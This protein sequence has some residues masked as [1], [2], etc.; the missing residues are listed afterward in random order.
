MEESQKIQGLTREEL[1]EKV[2]SLPGSKL[3][4]VLGISDVAIAKHCKKLNVPRPPRGY[5]NKVA[6]GHKPK[7]VPLPP[8]TAAVL[9]KE[10]T[11]PVRRRYELPQSAEALHPLAVKLEEAINSA[12]ADSDKRV[13]LRE[14]ELPLVKVTKALAQRT[15]QAFSVIL[16]ETELDKIPFRKSRASYESGYFEYKNERLHL[17][18][19]EAL[20]DTTRRLTA[21][22]KRNYGFPW[23]EFAKDPSG[24]LTFTL[25]TGNSWYVNKNVMHTW[26][27]DSKNAVEKFLPQIVREICQF[28][29][30]VRKRKAQ[31]AIER[32]KERVE[33]E[34]RRRKY[35]EELAIRQRAEREREH[36][37][38]LDATADARGKDLI[39]AAEWWRLHQTA[40]EFIQAC[41]ERWRSAQLGNLTAEQQSWIDWAV[42]T[43]KGLS[44][45]E[46]G[47]P[48]PAIDGLF[49]KEGVPFGGPYP[50]KRDFPRPP[51]MPKI[52]TPIVQSGYGAPSPK[53][54]APYPFWLKYQR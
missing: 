46:N 37:K 49:D 36:K 19:E 21:A 48:D 35:E 13:S 5:W 1:Y 3:S 9:E 32:E 51:T 40:S 41:E 31:E 12:K 54:E 34:E 8:S 39:K 16:T 20:N 53:A 27:E 23:P 29:V 43:I 17:G 50:S 28:Y 38:A 22:E 11:K 52:P 26:V 33:A 4:G 25:S 2:W 6:A 24:F 14:V 47:Y 18:I 45:F 7:R 10:V 30:D 15:S 42:E 44:P